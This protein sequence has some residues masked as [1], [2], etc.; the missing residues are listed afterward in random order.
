MTA[1]EDIPGGKEMRTRTGKA[2]IARSVSRC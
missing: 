2:F 1:A